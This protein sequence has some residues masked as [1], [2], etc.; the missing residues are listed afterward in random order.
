M[1]V[2]IQELV[3]V[4]NKAA[5][6]RYKFNDTNDY[7]MSSVLKKFNNDEFALTKKIK[8]FATNGGVDLVYFC[9]TVEPDVK[10]E[11]PPKEEAPS[12]ELPQELKFAA[13]PK[14]LANLCSKI[15]EGTIMTLSR[16]GALD[17]IVKEEIK[18]IVNNEYGHIVRP[19]TYQFEDG[20]KYT[21]EGLVH[22][23]FEKILGY[24]I[25][26]IP[27]YMYGPAGS[28]KGYIARQVAKALDLPF[29]V[30]SGVSDEFQLFGFTDANGHY[31]ETPFYHCYKDG[32]V[33]FLDEMDSSNSTALETLNGF[34]AD[35]QGAF[36]APTGLVTMHKNFRLIGAGNT[37]GDGADSDY[38]ARDVLDVATL[39]RFAK[40]SIEYDK[41][42]E[43]GLCP[44][45]EALGFLR[46]LR[47]AITKNSIN[48]VIISYRCMERVTKAIAYGFKKVDILKECV[49]PNLSRDDLNTLVS[50]VSGY[51][52]WSDA[53]D[54]L[55]KGK[56]GA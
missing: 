46:A 20:R 40:V 25:M 49:V 41:N 31:I 8:E 24:C 3:K 36:P 50:S 33:F 32:G 38:T 53:F 10:V 4:F 34:I 1:E 22:D 12:K 45:K 51:G 48:R 30:T 9:Q 55:A 5:H 13:D 43:A 18:N 2:R 17:E 15:A 7:W 44:D 26:E 54:V 39:D 16:E 56:Q 21:P 37:L 35:G 23:A 29:G 14:V 28:G 42:V 52:E 11:E 6:T 47:K 27:V 19:I